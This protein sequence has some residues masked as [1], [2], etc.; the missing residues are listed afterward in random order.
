[1]G[2]SGKDLKCILGRPTQPGH[3]ASLGYL[4]N[5]QKHLTL[6]PSGSSK[7]LQMECRVTKYKKELTAYKQDCTCQTQIIFSLKTE[8]ILTNCTLIPQ[9]RRVGQI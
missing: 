8:V 6:L 9:R 1:M 4:S 5:D 3:P 7:A 2:N